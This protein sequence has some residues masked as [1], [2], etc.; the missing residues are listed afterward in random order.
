MKNH[1]CLLLLFSLLVGCASKE[2]AAVPN[3]PQS[4]DAKLQEVIADYFEAFEDIRVWRKYATDEFIRRS[5]VWCTGDSS[6][7][8]SINEMVHIY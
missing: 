2:T 1:F 6:N 8:R 7:E 3:A 5:Y 4:E